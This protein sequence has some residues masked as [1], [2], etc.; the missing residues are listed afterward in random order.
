MSNWWGTGSRIP[1]FLSLL[2][3]HSVKNRLFRGFAL[4]S[5]LL[6][7]L[8]LPRLEQVLRLWGLN[9]S[10]RF[11]LIIPL[12]IL[13]LLPPLLFLPF[14]FFFL[15]PLLCFLLLSHL[16]FQFFVQSLAHRHQSETGVVYS[17]TFYFCVFEHCQGFISWVQLLLLLELRGE[18]LPVNQHIKFIF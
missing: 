13:S 7:G 1:C 16:L 11:M 18:E 15:L 12:S 6:L 8:L 9:C 10:L 3:A 2:P 4:L 17:L 5:L 14:C